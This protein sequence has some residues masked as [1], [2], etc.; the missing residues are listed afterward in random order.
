MARRAWTLFLWILW[1]GLAAIWANTLVSL[2]SAGF[3][4]YILLAVLLL[5]CVVVINRAEGLELAVAV[6]LH[7]KDTPRH[8]RALLST[9]SRNVFFR[10]RQLIVIF[11]VM[12]CGVATVYPWLQIPGYGIARGAA[13]FWFSVLFPSISIMW[14]AQIAPK[15]MAMTNPDLFITVGG[16][17]IFQAINMLDH[18]DLTGPADDVAWFLNW[19]RT[20]SAEFAGGPIP[21]A[22]V[23]P[24]IYLAEHGCDVDCAI[25]RPE[26]PSWSSVFRQVPTLCPC[27]RCRKDGPVKYADQHLECSAIACLGR[28]GLQ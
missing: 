18:F 13:P 22:W 26:V 28:F 10:Q 27:P 17:A 8:V 23:P 25:C 6:L 11:L 21:D 1:A 9:I 24:T 19:R 7:S 12:F 20:N 4:R 14:F 15:L 2:W 16:R 3:H 5:P